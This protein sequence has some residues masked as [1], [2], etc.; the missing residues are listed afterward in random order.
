[1]WLNERDLT[2]TSIEGNRKWAQKVLER[3]PNAD[4]WLIPGTPKD[5]EGGYWDEYVDAIDRFENDFFDIVIIDGMCREECAAR[6]APKV[7]PGG[8]I[9]VDDTDQPWYPAVP[10]QLPGWRRDRVMGFKR[11]TKPLTETSFFYKPSA[12]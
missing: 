4:V 10:E 6:A 1:M 11:A 9:V 8:I 2:V 3:C 7:K 12:T 5:G